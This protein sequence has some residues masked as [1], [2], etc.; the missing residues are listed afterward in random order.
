MTTIRRGFADIAEGQMHYRSAGPQRS[1]KRPLVMLHGSPESSAALV[2]VIRGLAAKRPVIAFDT[3]GQGDS[4][5]PAIADPDIVYFAGAVIRATES[6]GLGSFD[7]YGFHTGARIATEVAIAVPK[8]VGKVILD[9]MSDGV[10]AM[11]REYVKT[12]DNSHLIDQEGTQ[13]IKIW[14]KTRDG[15]LFW[16][17]YKRDPAHWRG[18]GLPHAQEL[19]DRMMD[20]LKSVRCGHMAYQAAVLYPSDQR[21]PLLTCPTLA[22]C[23]PKDSPWAYLDGVGRLLK[24]G[25]KRPYPHDNPMNRSS[26]AEIAAVVAMFDEWLG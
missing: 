19:H 14:N 12:L 15:Y 7:L 23:A 4:A 21:L 3:L 2:R 13:F 5:Q 18:L 16:P 20:T 6:L 9:G 10:N 17:P 24:N 1:D 25:T 11:Y 22:T 8:R 26:D